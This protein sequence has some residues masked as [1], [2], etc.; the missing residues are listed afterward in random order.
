MVPWLS[1][2]HNP[3]LWPSKPTSGTWNHVDIISVMLWKD[4]RTTGILLRRRTLTFLCLN[5]GIFFHR[6]TLTFLCWYTGIFFRRRTLTFLCAYT[7]IR[8][9][10]EAEKECL[11]LIYTTRVSLLLWTGIV[12]VGSRHFCLIPIIHGASAI[13]RL[14]G[15]RASSM[16]SW[17]CVL[18]FLKR[19]R[20]IYS[21]VCLSQKR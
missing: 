7:G 21:Y 19:L 12:A 10:H 16:R 15:S 18:W 1:Y 13:S 20:R 6:R 14:R 2:P 3:C 9:R 11:L 4:K 5:T 8:F 17:Q